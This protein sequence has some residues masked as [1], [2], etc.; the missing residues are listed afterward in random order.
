MCRCTLIFFTVKFTFSFLHT[1]CYTVTCPCSLYLSQTLAVTTLH[2]FVF[3]L[4][5][6][7]AI[8]FPRNGS[9]SFTL[10]LLCFWRFIRSVKLSLQKVQVMCEILIR[11]VSRS[12]STLRFLLADIFKRLCLWIPKCD[13]TDTKAITRPCFLRNIRLFCYHSE[14]LQLPFRVLGPRAHSVNRRI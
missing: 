11:G 4:H 3:I 8:Y 7:Q 2:C 10:Q 6:P 9:K 1:E 13:D 12:T 14:Y 5:E